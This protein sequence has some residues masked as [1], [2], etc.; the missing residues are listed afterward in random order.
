AGPIG[1]QGIKGDQGP[2]G[3][4]GPKGEPAY[5]F[6]AYAD[7]QAGTG[8]SLTDTSKRYMGYYSNNNPTQSA[9][10]SSYKWVDRSNVVATFMQSTAPA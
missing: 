3:L 5:F 7:D 2:K 10:A 1:P 6:M 9:S 4:I 8:F